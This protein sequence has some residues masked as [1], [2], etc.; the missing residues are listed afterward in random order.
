MNVQPVRLPEIANLLTGRNDGAMS[1]EIRE[2][3]TAP[4][5]FLPCKYFYDGRGSALFERICALPEYYQTR[6]ELAILRR[7]APAIMENLSE[8]NLIELGSGAN[9]KV[10]MLLDA[11]NGTRRKI[12]YVPIDVCEPMLQQAAADLLARYPELTIR[13]IVADFTRNLEGIDLAGAKLIVFFGS[14]IGNFSEEDCIAL[15]RSVAR[16]MQRTDRFLVG[17]D[18]IKSRDLMEAAYNDTRGVTAQFNKNILTVVNRALHANFDLTLFD[19]VAFYHE[20]RECI[21]MHLCANRDLS[22]FVADL[23]LSITMKKGETIFT[24][25]CRKFSRERVERLADA[26]GLEIKRWFSDPR[27]WFSLVEMMPASS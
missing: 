11:A 25:I 26:A 12:R 1:R 3:L 9:R 7:A 24:E 4:R 23:N 18:M 8:G 14:T 10:R 27:E 19:H 17:V 22:V 16:S 20:R 15:L 13:G 5:K 6:T 2:G 21:E